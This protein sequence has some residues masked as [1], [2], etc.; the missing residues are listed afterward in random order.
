MLL[1]F[2]S[3]MYNDINELHVDNQL[4]LLCIDFSLKT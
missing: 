3:V 1:K 4:S 2:D